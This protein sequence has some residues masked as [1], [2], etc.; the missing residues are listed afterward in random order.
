MCRSLR[1]AAEWGRWQAFHP[2]C[3]YGKTA[4]MAKSIVAKPKLGRPSSG[5]RDPFVGIRLPETL[6]AQIR[7]WAGAHN[8][9]SRS[10]AI[11]RLVEIGLKAKK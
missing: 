9:P 1:D 11:R 8:A 6:I 5:G 3:L 2:A 10:E 4:F 7:D